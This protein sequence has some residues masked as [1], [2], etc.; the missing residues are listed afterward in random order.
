ML[1]RRLVLPVIA[2]AL[3]GGLLPRAIAATDEKT[4][5]TFAKP[6]A[7]KPSTYSWK[8]AVL[9]SPDTAG[10]VATPT[11]PS[12]CDAQEALCEDKTITVPE[13]S[14]STLYVRVAW[15]HPVWKAY[16]YV[17]APDGTLYP[18]NADASTPTQCDEDSF[19]KGC[20]NE[21]SLPVDEV[22]IRSPKPGTWRIRVAAVNMHD[23]AYTG[24][25]SLTNST[26]LE[27]AK[28]NLKELTARL[29]RSQPVNI[30]FAGWKPTDQELAD[31]KA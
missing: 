25:A 9:Q 13:V 2:L 29:T 18:S 1:R 12:A 28:E 16:L 8:G 11:S 17:I 21:T 15:Q 19:N 30:V 26:P 20:G 10:S 23:E 27:Y 31:L 4:D 24:M 6:T 5:F 14:P 3:V 22:T 7:G